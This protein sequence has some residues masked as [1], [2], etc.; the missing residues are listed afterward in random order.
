MKNLIK[1]SSVAIL[2]LFLSGCSVG[3][4]QD[5]NDII[6]NQQNEIDKLKTTVNSLA[7]SSALGKGEATPREIKNQ[8][9]TTTDKKTNSGDYKTYI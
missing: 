4:K 3:S 7:S 1:F 8:T 2:L 5:Y 9:A 6:K